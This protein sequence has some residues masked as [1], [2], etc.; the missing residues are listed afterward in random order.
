MTRPAIAERSPARF[1]HL[2]RQSLRILLIPEGD[3][4]FL[5]L[6]IIQRI[7]ETTARISGMVILPR[8]GPNRSA[9]GIALGPQSQMDPK[10]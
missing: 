3:V 2:D 7:S 1:L 10:P 8:R 9:Q 4:N 6:E 5:R